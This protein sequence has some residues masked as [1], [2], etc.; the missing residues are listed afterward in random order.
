[1]ALGHREWSRGLQLRVGGHL[2]V[3]VGAPQ[4]IWFPVFC[5]LLT[6]P[7]GDNGPGRGGLPHS[8]AQRES[9][10]GLFHI[11][12]QPCGTRET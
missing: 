4:G 1:M 6:R 9:E 2:A 10:Q 3:E 11:G 8:C 12:Q 7:V 5:P